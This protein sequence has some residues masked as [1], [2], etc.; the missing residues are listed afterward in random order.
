MITLRA[1]D[2]LTL[3][4]LYKSTNGP[5]WENKDGWLEANRSIDDWYG[6]TIRDDRVEEIN[7][8]NNNLVG[9]ISSSIGYL[10]NLRKLNL[11]KNNLSGNI[12]SIASLISLE[13]V[14]L[15][16]NNLTGTIPLEFGSLINLTELRLNNNSLTGIIPSGLG[17]LD[18]L[19]QLRLNNNNLTGSIPLELRNLT[20]IEILYLQNNEL[21][22]IEDII[23]LPINAVVDIENNKI[24]FLSIVP[25]IGVIDFYDNQLLDSKDTIYANPNDKLSLTISDDHPDNN[26]QWHK[27][28]KLI[29]NATNRIYSVEG[30]DLDDAGEYYATIKNTE[31]PGATSRRDTIYVFINRILDFD[32]LAL[33][34]FYNSTNGDG[35]SNND[36]WLSSSPIDSWHGVTI[37]NNRVVSLDL[38]R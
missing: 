7:L 30:F 10:D 3:I 14:V 27:D 29:E 33:V 32:S 16:D 22:S 38:E 11:S 2:S 1:A 25:N 35:W 31:A 18:N 37:D 15:S 13:E 20:N 17:S 24:G 28:D 21:D 4:D 9:S 6:I 12:F 19:T 23:S 26:Y 34:S 5:G 36:N 8:E